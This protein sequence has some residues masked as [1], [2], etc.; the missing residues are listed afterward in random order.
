MSPVEKVTKRAWLATSLNVIAL[1]VVGLTLVLALIGPWLTSFDPDRARPAERFKNWG[2][3]GHLLGT[4]QLGRDVLTRLI[5]GARLVWIV[6]LGVAVLAV[7]VGAILGVLAGYLG[8]RIEFIITRIAD[9]ILAFPP[10]L[11]ALILAAVM[12]PSTTT[13][14]IALSIVYTPLVLRV[15]RAAV[16]SERGQSY[17]LAARGLGNTESFTLMRH[18]V[19]NV[20]APLM[21]VG[22]VVVSRAII[23]EASL[24]FL[25]V[26]TQPPRSNWGV[27]IGEARETVFSR[28]SQLI[29]PAIVLSV[30]VICI[31]LVSDLVSDRLDPQKAVRR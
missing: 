28:P 29:L 24:S 9:G 31:N 23:I 26:G 14:I 3:D 20:L 5:E 7:L 16:I 13:A 17:V 2:E 19:P 6:G 18:V 11:L 22:S 27:M 10:L 8:G 25:G 1:S 21:V 30:V 12:R 4:D 15:T